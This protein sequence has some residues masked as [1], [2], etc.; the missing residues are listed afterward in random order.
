MTIDDARRNYSTY[1]AALAE[2]VRLNDILDV[3]QNMMH[4]WYGPCDALG[5]LGQCAACLE[6]LGRLGLAHNQ[7]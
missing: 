7:T 6:V 3:H 2:I 5:P 4:P 1:E